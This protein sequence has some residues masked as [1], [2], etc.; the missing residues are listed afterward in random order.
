VAYVLTVDQRH[1]RRGPDRV[2]EAI[3][4]L[5]REHRPVLGFERTV[6][7]EFQGVLEDPGEV[8][9][10]VLELV[11]MGGWSIGVGVGPVEAPLPA[12][13]RE[14]RGVAFILAREAVERAKHRSTGL[15]VAA[16]DAEAGREAQAVLDL[17]A[18]VLRRRTA[19][20]WDAV[21]LVAGGLSVTEAA[22]KLGV[23]RQAAGQRLAAGNWEQEREARPVA[24]N[25]LVR[26]S[27]AA[28]AAQVPAR[29]H[30]PAHAYADD[31]LAAT[32]PARR[33]QPVRH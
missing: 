7:D 4:R 11:R 13:T 23:S 21:D 14:A 30:V 29:A 20:A 10:V 15:A 17:L 1:S 19:A 31:R 32:T 12:S 6:G 3:S 26:A 5:A 18:V 24:A 9:S 22:A 28:S 16:V 2:P 27:L 33:A 25:L 8:V